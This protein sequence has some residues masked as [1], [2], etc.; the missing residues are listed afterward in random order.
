MNVG[1]VFAQ[2][3]LAESKTRG[4][5]QLLGRGINRRGRKQLKLERF[6]AGFMVLRQP[7]AV[8]LFHFG[9]K[10]HNLHRER[11]E[12]AVETV[13]DL[14]LDLRLQLFFHTGDRLPG[15]SICLL[16]LGVGCHFGA[17]VVFLCLFLAQNC[18]I[19]QSHRAPLIDLQAVLHVEDGAAHQ[20]LLFWPKRAKALRGGYAALEVLGHCRFPYVAFR[21]QLGHGVLPCRRARM[22]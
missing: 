3:L 10:L 2:L 17:E 11:K 19:G 5:V 4:E 16:P 7:L 8:R 20:P 15:V 14:A 12:P 9:N 1:I 13:K 22:A 21:Q 18:R 6:Q